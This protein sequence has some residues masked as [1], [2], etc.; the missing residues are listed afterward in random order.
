MSCL[1]HHTLDTKSNEASR[2]STIT[3]KKILMTTGKCIDL[4]NE[5]TLYLEH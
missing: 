2:C 1:M 5:D 3:A 4:E